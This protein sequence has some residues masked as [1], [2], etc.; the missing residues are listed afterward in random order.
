MSVNEILHNGPVAS[1][2]R[3]WF[4]RTYLKLRG[5][6]LAGDLPREG[7]YVLIGAPHTSNWDL[8]LMIAAT[9]IWRLRVSWMG[10]DSLF[11]SPW[12]GPMMRALGGM[13]IDRSN[14]RGAVGQIADLFDQCERMVL[15][16]AVSGTRKKTEYWRSGFYWIARAAKVPILCGYLDFGRKTCGVGLCFTPSGD[17]KADMD[18][19]REFYADKRG[20]H[21]QLESR[22][23]LRIEDEE[24]SA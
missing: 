5:W 15:V 23:R 24:V 1:P 16:V 2:W 17:V 9:G 14:P 3:Y 22:I 6:T 8:P 10:K 12:S 7:K 18:R 21:P 13:P 4:G 20:K 19:I 11:K